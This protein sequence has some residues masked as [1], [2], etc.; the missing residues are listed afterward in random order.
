LG[1]PSSSQNQKIPP[2]SIF[3]SPAIGDPSPFRFLCPSSRSLL[4]AMA[5]LFIFLSSSLPFLLLPSSQMSPAA[6]NKPCK[7]RHRFEI[8]PGRIG[9]QTFP[10]PLY[11]VPGESPSISPAPIPKYD[12]KAKLLPL[13]PPKKVIN[14]DYSFSEP[15]LYS[16]FDA[17]SSEFLHGLGIWAGSKLNRYS[18]CKD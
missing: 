5:T 18:Y 16:S 6:R 13:D 4:H 11:L 7:P 14:K 12:C 10:D 8:L 15:E 9:D 1:N 17:L 2:A 3:A